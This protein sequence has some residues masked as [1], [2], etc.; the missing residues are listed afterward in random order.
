MFQTLHDPT[1]LSWVEA[2]RTF[3]SYR[4]WTLRTGATATSDTNCI[5]S[6]LL[7]LGHIHL[8]PIVDAHL[9]FLIGW[10]TTGFVVYPKSTTGIS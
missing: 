9:L 7:L 4:C 8:T 5:Q 1:I 3:Q 10:I 2:S 6:R